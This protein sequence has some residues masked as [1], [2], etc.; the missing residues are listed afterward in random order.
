MLPSIIRV[1]RS[2]CLPAFLMQMLECVHPD[3]IHSARFRFA[4][5]ITQSLGDPITLDL[6][7]ATIRR[8]AEKSSSS[9]FPYLCFRSASI[10]AETP[11]QSIPKLWPVLWLLCADQEPVPLRGVIS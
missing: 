5:F 1:K 9:D 8:I 11:F 2:L 7:E 4:V 6:T 10:V 3:R